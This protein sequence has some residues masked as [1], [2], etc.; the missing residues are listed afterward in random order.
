VA[1]YEIIKAFSPE[2]FV[3]PEVEYI[4]QWD[5]AR[6]VQPGL[7]V[8][9]D[10]DLTRPTVNLLT[11]KSLPRTYTPS[12]YEF[13]DYPGYYLQKPDGEHY[14]AVRIDEF[15]TQFETAHAVTNARGVTVGALF[16]LEGYP[17]ADQNHEHVIVGASY[18]MQFS[19]Y[20]A[21]P[22]DEGP[23]TYAC[24][25]AAMSSDQQFRP[26][27][28][29][30]K[31]FVQG[32]QT[33]EVVGPAGDEIYTDEHG[34]VKVK[35]HWDRDPKKDQNSSCWIRVSQMWAGK[36]WG[37]VSTP[38]I[39]HEV[40]VDFLEGDP[41][42]P[43]ILGSVHN[44]VNPPPHTG[45]VSGLKSN[46]HKGRG[47]N[48]MTMDDTAGKEQ[49]TIHAQHDLKTT[50]ENDETHTLVSGKRSM[51]VQAGTN[52][53]VIKGNAS[54]TIQAGTRSVDVTGGDYTAAATAMV[55][56]H[57][58]GKGV[59]VTGTPNVDI[60]GTAT[61]T[62]DSPNIDVGKALIKIHGTK[63]ELVT[64]G[65][66]ITLDASGVSI[67]GIKIQSGADANNE[68]TGAKVALNGGGS[69]VELAAGGA[70]MS[71]SKVTVAAAGATEIT[72]SVVKIN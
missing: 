23:P 20:E 18:D 22:T 70:N 67:R 58:K 16:T 45:V 37:S 69:S 38:R 35:F 52:T 24:R 68:I 36:G 27:R 5:F 11:Q 15:G 61:L 34:R 48:Q 6:E 13:Y 57:G 14:A 8:H 17:R 42:Q 55:S 53:E 31:P 50:I 9:T 2:Q 10:Y 62:I 4:S 71:G 12:D 49:I 7:F 19:D 47:S 30:P 41:D 1:G 64:A 28:A 46:T 72:G 51:T 3:R 29:T 21:M 44:A 65:G 60:T 43:I 59:I 32:P 63:I 40:I 39:G 54:L 56:L 26:K 25:F 33:A 66:S